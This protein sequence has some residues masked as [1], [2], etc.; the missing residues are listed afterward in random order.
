MG[1][2][3][4]ADV[5][6]PMC[7]KPNP[8][9]AEACAYCGAR[10]KPLIIRPTE[11]AQAPQAKKPAVPDA[12]RPSASAPGTDWLGR[13]R[14][15]AVIEPEADE[16]QLGGE[17][18]TGE[19]PGEE[20][21]WLSRIGGEGA[22]VTDVSGAHEQPP[23][24]SDQVVEHGRPAEEATAPEGSAWFRR[25]RERRKSKAASAEPTE[26][27]P[28]S[29][30]IQEV[31]PPSAP[32]KPRIAAGPE[33][34][35]EDWLG[36][37]RGLGEQ[38]AEGRPAPG[39]AERPSGEFPGWLSDLDSE[40]EQAE[41]KKV[42]DWL[43]R[44]RSRRATETDGPEPIARPED[45]DWLSGLRDEGQELATEAEPSFEPVSTDLPPAAAELEP[46]A[47]PEDTDW[48]SGLRGESQELA[49]EAEP[50]FEPI[51]TDLPVP[52]EELG[53]TARPE[54]TDWLSGLRGEGQELAAEAEPPFEPI[55]TEL[56]A[57]ADELGPTARPDDDIGWLS[58]LRGEGQEPA[59]EAEPAFE[60]LFPDL[61][62]AAD[63]LGPTAR[64]VDDI[65]WL[66]GLRGESQEL[67][68]EAEPA[69]EP[70]FPDLRAP[71]EEA[72]PSLGP[73]ASDA[74]TFAA[75][76]G[77]PQSER[78]LGEKPFV[79]EESSTDGQI[80]GE[81]PSWRRW[82]SILEEQGASSG[83]ARSEEQETD[84]STEGPSL[85][86]PS[87][88]VEDELSARPALVERDPLAFPSMAGES[89][90]ERTPTWLGSETTVR[91]DSLPHVQPLIIDGERKAGPVPETAA[92]E[93]ET[94]AWFRELSPE[95][96]QEEA[97][98]PELV[99][100]ELAPATLPAWLEAMRPIEGFRS[101]LEIQSE[102][103][104]VVEAAGPLAGLPGV[105]LAEPVVAMPRAPKYGG[106][107]LE[108]TERHFAQEQELRLV[109]QD[110][111]RE[112]PATPSARPSLPL[113]RW[114]ITLAMLMGMILPTV[115]GSPRFGAPK[116][117]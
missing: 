23:P 65:D 114:A 102:E 86:T 73:V 2:D 26:P 67:A 94:P 111:E 116:F 64:P 91:D 53:P 40:A 45:T 52:A 39:A 36:R 46:V 14:A 88:L 24:G 96:T 11:E 16:G 71:A 47:P 41:E 75:E 21:G 4:M 76:P 99:A 58:G 81:E 25:V 31:A 78:P 22:K 100:S 43:A 105:L 42:P 28:A 93:A 115:W 70:L 62:G 37:L 83:L 107:Q 61:P 59:A 87:A 103:E 54:D 51:F 33:A 60:P 30:P 50:P 8:A 106:A 112:V 108:I 72:E 5:R 110:E 18:E 85:P 32:E 44:I 69:F 3:G 9:E 48:L 20:S 90:E 89:Q 27:S 82:S 12:P 35:S 97:P 104:R 6:C 113:V 19:A 1:T 15:K 13:I 10:I 80:P 49:A 57:P 101:V 17:A 38:E 55:P 7:S 109:V 56:P 117:V 98:T 66:T 68:A 34:Q 63:E 92:E 95:A 77:P 74:A 79:F 84:A 29:G